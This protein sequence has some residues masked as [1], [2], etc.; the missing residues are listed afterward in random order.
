MPAPTVVLAS[1]S[2]YRRALLERLGVAVVT[3]AP[4]VDERAAGAGLGPEEQA[5]ALARAKAEAVPASPDEL[6]V[7]GDQVCALGEEVL[8]KPGDAARAVD[9]LLRMQGRSHELWTAVHLRCGDRHEAILDRTVLTMR[10]LDEAAIRRYVA[11]DAPF[12]CAGSYKLEAAGIALFERVETEDHTAV[13]GMP[14]MAVV[15]AFGR[16]GLDLP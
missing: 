1:T 8:H 6:V 9:Q 16:F 15:A 2:P 12:D 10:R 4:G 3:R 7:A 13:I 14:M 5:V 11:L